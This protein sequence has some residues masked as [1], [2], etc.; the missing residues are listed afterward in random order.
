MNSQPPS[1]L[2]RK[3]GE[4]DGSPFRLENFWVRFLSLE[5][6]A[7]AHTTVEV[8]TEV[9]GERNGSVRRNRDVVRNGVVQ[10]EGATHVNIGIVAGN[11]VGLVKPAESNL[12]TEGA[13][14]ANDSKL[15]DFC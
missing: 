13:A 14:V 4:P 3:K 2:G 9:V 8:V 10:G 11:G 5:S 15:F 6:E 7:N 1:P 12:S